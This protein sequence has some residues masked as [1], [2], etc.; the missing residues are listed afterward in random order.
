MSLLHLSTPVLL[1]YMCSLGADVTLNCHCN[2][3]DLCWA[4]SSLFKRLDKQ[5]QNRIEFWDASNSWLLISSTNGWTW[6]TWGIIKSKWAEYMGCTA[7]TIWMWLSTRVFSES[8]MKR[9]KFSPGGYLFHQ[10]QLSLVHV[11]S[12]AEKQGPNLK[13]RSHTQYRVSFGQGQKGLHL[14]LC[15][16]TTAVLILHPI[17]KII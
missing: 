7:D 8:L 1:I 10:A 4:L 16:W 5:Q 15:W 2:Q 3:I 9:M 14:L 11:G 17:N 6:Q 13:R 12:F